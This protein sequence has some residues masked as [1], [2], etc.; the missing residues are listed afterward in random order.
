LEHCKQ[1]RKMRERERERERGEEVA[2][3]ENEDLVETR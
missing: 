1:V 3:K 2:E